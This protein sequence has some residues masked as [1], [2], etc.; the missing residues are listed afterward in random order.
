MR[1]PT[2]GGT[3]WS[4]SKWNEE[5]IMKIKLPRFGVSM[6]SSLSNRFRNTRD[7]EPVR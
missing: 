7:V 6:T 1:Q 4:H 5:V 2:S 3:A